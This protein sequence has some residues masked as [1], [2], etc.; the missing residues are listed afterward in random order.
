MHRIHTNSTQQINRLRDERALLEEEVRQL[1]AAV[2]IY[3]EVARRMSQRTGFTTSLRV[4]H[5]L[6]SATS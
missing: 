2:Q 3:A 5:D 4:S 1:R 6:Q